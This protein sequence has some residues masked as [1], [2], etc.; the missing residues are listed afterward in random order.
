MDIE[1]DLE[2]DALNL[3]KHGVSLA[4]AEDFDIQA[5]IEDPRHDEVRWRAYGVLDGSPHCL[6][7]TLRG[8][9]VRAI[10]LRRAHLKEFRRY[11]PTDEE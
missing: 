6:A 3:A 2:K 5:V 9:A 10:S 4:R 1:F 7:F 8:A 11:V